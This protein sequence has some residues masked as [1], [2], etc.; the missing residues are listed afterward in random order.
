MIN[1]DIVGEFGIA[2]EKVLE[3]EQLELFHIDKIGLPT[4]FQDILV[5]YPPAKK[6]L[7]WKDYTAEDADV[8]YEYAKNGGILVLIPPFNPEYREKLQEIFEKFKISPIFR[9][10]K[11]LA[12]V[13]A[14]MLNDGQVSK[15]PIVKF[16]HFLTQE[17]ENLEI[18]IE[19]NYKPIFAFLFVGTGAVVLYGLGSKLFWQEDLVSIF[20]Y[21][22]KDYGYFWEKSELT[23]KQLENVLNC[24]R[25]E[26][27]SKI[28]DEFVNTFV[29]KKRFNSFLE[30]KDSQLKDQLLAKIEDST[31]ADEFKDLSGKFIVK[32][33][34][35]LHRLLHH[36]YPSLIKK[37]QKFLFSKVIDQT[38]NEKTF[39]SLYES[40][41]LPSEAAYLLI[42]YLNP[43]DPDNYKK[44]KDNLGRLIQ[45]NK[46]EQFFDEA[47]LKELAWKHL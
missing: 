7:R 44:F 6:K 45:W 5:V 43:E 33:Y 15:R 20:K 28:Q 9:Q 23:E 12:H 36:A 46:K 3:N 30:I 47:Y 22:K 18:L 38:I 16:V 2:P 40:D 19:G 4:E 11:L 14:H 1:I 32:K 41:L 35:E 21:L 42:F 25:E 13:N 17:T 26:E 27:R 8:L 24:S 29:Q 31:I 10:E 34:R 39:S 37:L